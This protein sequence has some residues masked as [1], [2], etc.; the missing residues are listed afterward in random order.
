V[1]A[2]Y[3]LI[4]M[5]HA[6]ETSHDH[7]PRFLARS[8]LYLGRH[9][10]QPWEPNW[11]R[12]NQQHEVLPCL[13]RADTRQYARTANARTESLPIARSLAATHAHAYHARTHDCHLCVCTVYIFTYI[14]P[15]YPKDCKPSQARAR[16]HRGAAAERR[17]GD[18][19]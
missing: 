15:L 6:P 7:E 4:C 10:C 14:T 11:T 13:A 19:G 3:V 2:F 8:L 17:S 1:L 18:S 16:T 9:H 12:S 5:K